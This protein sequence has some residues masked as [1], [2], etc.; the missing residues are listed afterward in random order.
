[1]ADPG[2]RERGLKAAFHNPR[3]S[4][5]AKERDRKILATEFGEHFEETPADAASI[6]PED[7][8]EELSEVEYEQIAPSTR[9]R[10]TTGLHASSARPET[11]YAA[12]KMSAS[13][14]IEPPSS[15]K[16]RGA[17]RGSTGASLGE[18]D[19][20]DAGNVIRGLKAAISNPNVSEQAKDKDRK[21]LRELGEAVE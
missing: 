5:Q 3:V 15:G 17:R 19:G 16:T 4:E 8:S 1:M 6:E 13:E 21:K 14:T 18:I 10:Q 2:N 12:D 9:A 20:K 7:S 11:S